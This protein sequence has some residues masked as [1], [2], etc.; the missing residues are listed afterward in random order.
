MTES[1]IPVVDLRDFHDPAR[2]AEFVRV[3]GEGLEAF[4]FVALQ[5]HGVSNELLDRCY[6]SARDVFALPAETK[7]GYEVPEEGRQR[8][9]TS[10]GVEKAKDRDVADIK[11]FWQVGR[12]LA[13][14]HPYRQGGV[15]PANRWPDE[16]PAFREA[17]TEYFTT[18]E[19][20]TDSLLVAIAEYLGLAPDYFA[21]VTRDGNTVIRA[22]NYPEQGVVEAGAVRAAEHEDINLITILPASTKPG[23]ELMTREGEWMSVM[24]PPG[25]LVADTGDMMNRLTAGKLP[26]TTHRVVNPET[27]DGGRQ[28]MPFFVHP[29]PDFVITPMVEGFAEPIRAD[30]YLKQRL[31]EI[32][33]M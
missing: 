23:L 5:G 11:E 21:D 28:S 4:G 14:D 3:L 18:M 13:D 12:E 22:L 32:G 6:G 2:R 30:E 27:S 29:R 25:V 33:V 7:A 10:F 8:G 20:I 9:Y 19:S 15:V 24:V 1:T 26:A 16:V 31:I 17:Y